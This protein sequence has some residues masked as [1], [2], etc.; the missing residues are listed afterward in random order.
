MLPTIEPTAAS[1]FG[2]AAPASIT[3]SFHTKQAPCHRYIWQGLL[4]N[5]STT[6]MTE[7]HRPWPTRRGDPNL[8]G[9]SPPRSTPTSTV[10]TLTGAHQSPHG[11]CPAPH[12]RGSDD[13]IS[14]KQASPSPTPGTASVHTPSVIRAPGTI[15]PSPQTTM[16][17]PCEG[18]TNPYS[19]ARYG[20]SHRDPP[21]SAGSHASC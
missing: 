4:C 11:T 6:D 13:N 1:P 5:I 16:V 20:T 18:V 2:A 21:N 12:H 19:H 10:L 17:Q 15:P 9:W 3:R 14:G 8:E 7:Y